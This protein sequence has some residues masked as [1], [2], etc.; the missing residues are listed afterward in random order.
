[1]DKNLVL[2]RDFLFKWFIIGF[3]LYFISAVLYILLKD[4][5]AEMSFMLFQVPPDYYYSAAFFLL[6]FVKVF[7]FF[8]LL[9]SALALH[10][11][12]KK[13]QNPKK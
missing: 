13:M 7:L 4:F 9:P 1:M 10:W 11:M 2:F 5:S 8:F 6:N 12:V 3:S